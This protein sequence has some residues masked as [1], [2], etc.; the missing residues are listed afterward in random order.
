M[1]SL[2]DPSKG[3]A[4][5]DDQEGPTGVIG[6]PIY[7]LGACVDGGSRLKTV[8]QDCGSGPCLRLTGVEIDRRE[9]HRRGCIR[10]PRLSEPLH[11]EPLLRK[12]GTHAG[13]ETNSVRSVQNKRPNL[14]R[15]H[16]MSGR[17][18]RASGR[19]GADKNGGCDE[20]EPHHWKSRSDSGKVPIACASVPECTL[21]DPGR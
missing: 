19:T 3:G 6:K 9:R 15:R 1:R 18:F 14:V 12:L 16:R 8:S 11:A 21:S 13:R 20:R 7:R 10:H 17:R 5:H 4:K 2:A